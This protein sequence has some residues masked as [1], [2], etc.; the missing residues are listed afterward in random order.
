MKKVLLILLT[1][2]ILTGCIGLKASPKPEKQPEAEKP[3]VPQAPMPT[4]FPVDP[5]DVFV[6]EQNQRLGRGINLGNALEA[7]NEGEWGMTLEESFFTTIHQGGFHSVRVPIRWSNHAASEPPYL[8]EKAFFDRIDWVVEQAQKNDL[9][10]ILNMH[11]YQEMMDTPKEHKARFLAM[12]KQIAEHYQKAPD[13]V[14][15]EILNEPNGVLS[16]GGTWNSLLAET[17]QLIR[18]TNPRRTIIV[19]PANWNSLSDLS[20]LELPQQER[21]LIIT[22]HY[23]QPFQFTHQGADWVNGSDSWLGTTWTA[24]SIEK[25]AVLGD[26]DF[27]SQWGKTNHRPLFLGEFGAFSKADMDSRALWT[28][29]LARKAEQHGMSWAYWEFGAGFGAYDREAKKWVE[30]IYHAL[31]PQ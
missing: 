12:W 30:P 22:F 29:F 8:I 15:F 13:S 6:Y 25:N 9:A 19:G 4:L 3:A 5:G 20:R 21:N 10:V 1:T 23:Y 7:P 24:K 14:Y 16:L 26:L 31:I 11:H 18:E 17:V 27:A 28:D 2:L